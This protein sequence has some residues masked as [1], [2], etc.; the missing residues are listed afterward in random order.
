MVSES[1]EGPLEFLG[2]TDSQLKVNGFRI[3][4]GEI[5]AAILEHP[6]VAQTAV[7]KR[8][9]TEKTTGLVAF[10]QPM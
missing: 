6:K 7:T 9:L 3:E 8:S 2:R 4:P 10:I 5:E 1:A